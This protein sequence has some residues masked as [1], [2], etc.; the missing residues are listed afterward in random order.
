MRE[1][2]CTTRCAPSI[3][4]QSSSPSWRVA[5]PADGGEVIAGS[6]LPSL[7]TLGSLLPPTI[8]AKQILW[9][10]LGQLETADF[11]QL[12]ALIYGMFMS[13]SVGAPQ[14]L[15][16][17]Q[18]VPS[19]RCHPTGHGW[20]PQELMEYFDTDIVDILSYIA[21]Q[22]CGEHISKL[23]SGLQVGCVSVS[24]AVCR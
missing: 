11:H 22:G 17:R 15:A 20:A 7:Y 24:V 12:C 16:I 14:Q 2:V 4:T 6:Q 10:A 3:H 1:H 9:P 23:Q 19:V 8:P 21:L 18:R 5:G 13:P